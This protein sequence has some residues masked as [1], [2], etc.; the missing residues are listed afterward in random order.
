VE[1]VIKHKRNGALFFSF[2]ILIVMVINIGYTLVSFNKMI[3]AVLVHG[4]PK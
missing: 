3:E 2:V 1:S 4:A